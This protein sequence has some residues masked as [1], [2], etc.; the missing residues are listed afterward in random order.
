MET[1]KGK[2][3]RHHKRH[4]IELRVRYTGPSGAIEQIVGNI[5]MGGLRI[6]GPISDREGDA[7]EL[8]LALPHLPGPV[9][10]HGEVVWVEREAGNDLA[11]VGVR[12]LDLDPTLSVMLG[13][14]LR[15]GLPT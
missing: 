9:R 7:V 5:S 4:S 2:P 3:F 14:I 12:F 8:S 10:V 11:T 6:S 1:G 15:T 13:H